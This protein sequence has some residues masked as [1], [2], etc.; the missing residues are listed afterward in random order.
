MLASLAAPSRDGNA[1]PRKLSS[2]CANICTDTA[3]LSVAASNSQYRAPRCSA[4]RNA[5]VSE[6]RRWAIVSFWSL[7][8]PRKTT[9][10]RPTSYVG[11]L[12]RH[13]SWFHLI[14]VAHSSKLY[15]KLTM[16]PSSNLFG[17]ATPIGS[18]CLR[19]WLSWSS[20]W[21]SLSS[22]SSAL[23]SWRR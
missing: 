9:M 5:S 13:T 15:S 19:A 6:S 18:C 11:R 14:A 1:C 23:V 12:R 17:R 4:G 21:R 10:A 22:M 8:R 3:S 7:G 16:S 2:R 20:S